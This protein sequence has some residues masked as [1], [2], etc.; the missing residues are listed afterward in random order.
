MN[1]VKTVCV[2]VVLISVLFA[3]LTLHARDERKNRGNINQGISRYEE[4]KAIT[5]ADEMKRRVEVLPY[6]IGA[7]DEIE[8]E[9]VLHPELSG[10]FIVDYNGTIALPMTG[11]EVPV[12]GLTKYEA[13]DKLKEI[14]S[15]YVAEPMVTV[16]VAGFRGYK[17]KFVYVMGEIGGYSG[18]GSG[19]ARGGGDEDFQGGG[20]NSVTHYAGYRIP[21]RQRNMTVRDAIMYAGMLGDNAAMRRVLV[22]TPSYIGKPKIQKVDMYK[23][24]FRGDLRDNILLNPGDIV[25][26]PMTVAAKLTKTI[27]DIMAPINAISMPLNTYFMYKGL[28][29]VGDKTEEASKNQPPPTEALSTT[30]TTTEVTEEGSTTTST[31]TTDVGPAKD[32]IKR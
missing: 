23:V 19:T 12:S 29:Y 15:D 21:F 11:Q 5:V 7:D 14:I 30:I 9:V 20:G 32:Y 24:F 10:K 22:I 27:T 2:T 1:F 17:S 25:Y 18:G 4:E 31:T 26:V 16:K 13:R 6:I 3:P 8:V 28:L